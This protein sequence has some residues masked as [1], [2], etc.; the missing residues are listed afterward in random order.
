M[1]TREREPLPTARKATNLA[2]EDALLGALILD[3]GERGE[4]IHGA[5]AILRDT[6]AFASLE[7]REIAE[8]MIEL[9]REAKP[10]DLVLLHERLLQRGTL[11]EVGGVDRLISLI[12]HVPTAK[13][14][15]HYARI[16]ASAWGLTEHELALP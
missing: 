14:A 4:R 9:T 13:H 10:V 11:A 12:E 3:S 2:A 5:T 7:N 8:A 1:A 16:V 6:H 15:M